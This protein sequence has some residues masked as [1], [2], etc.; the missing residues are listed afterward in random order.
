MT[1]EQAARRYQRY[2]KP[3]QRRRRKAGQCVSCE[4]PVTEINPRTGRLFWRCPTHR[5]M[6]QRA[7][8]RYLAPL[9][10]ARLAAGLCRDC[11]CEADT[12]RR[13]GAP[14]A[15][16]RDCRIKGS[17]YSARLRARLKQDRYNRAI[18]AWAT[19]RKA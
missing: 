1:P 4:A 14:Y 8:A 19:R 6:A 18:D 7:T 10:A 16:C 15:R 17:T 9:K 11:G 5:D 3:G 13:T 2:D 12:N